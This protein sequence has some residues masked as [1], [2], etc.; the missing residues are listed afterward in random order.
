MFNSRGALVEKSGLI[1]IPRPPLT[2]KQYKTDFSFMPIDIL[3]TV[4]AAL[5]DA[6][7][8]GC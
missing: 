3:F 4:A 6:F 7:I 5:S 8:P 2:L 1:I